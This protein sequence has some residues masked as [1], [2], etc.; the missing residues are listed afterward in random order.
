VPV[1]D[2][3]AMSQAAHA[4]LLDDSIRAR[5]G[6]AARELALEGY[7]LEQQARRYQDLY[8]SMLGSCEAAG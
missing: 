2:V 1:G 5:M 8:R 3:R 4:V 7:G 6:R